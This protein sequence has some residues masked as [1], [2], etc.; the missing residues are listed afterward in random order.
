MAALA[1]ETL[2]RKSL[3][4]DIAPHRRQKSKWGLQVMSEFAMPGDTDIL[5]G[6]PP[7]SDDYSSVQEFGE[8]KPGRDAKVA[9][10]GIKL[11][12][13]Y[14]ACVTAAKGAA[15]P[16]SHED[17]VTAAWGA[18]MHNLWHPSQFIKAEAGYMTCTL[19]ALRI[20]CGQEA[21]HGR[22]R[23]HSVKAFHAG[24]KPIAQCRGIKWSCWFGCSCGQWHS[25]KD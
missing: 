14:P 16:G 12:P 4:D 22:G 21:M 8:W 1:M 5:R 6:S 10:D 23:R 19:C 15:M 13:G 17:I 2:S 18:E 3:P 20:S 24:K 25:R 7:L 9:E 11:P